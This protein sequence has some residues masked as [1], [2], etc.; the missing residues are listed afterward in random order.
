MLQVTQRTS[1]EAFALVVRRPGE[2]ELI[3]PLSK[4]NTSVGR[5][6]TCDIVIDAP[7]LSRLHA[8]IV[9]QNGTYQVHDQG[10]TT[11]IYVTGQ[12]VTE[13]PLR[14]D[15]P[16]RIPDPYGNVTTLTGRY[17]TA[18]DI[19]PSSPALLS[20]PWRM[21]GLDP[22]RTVL[23]IG[24]DS[25]NDVV[26]DLPLVSRWHARIERQGQILLIRDLNSVNG[27][28]V[29]GW[30]VQ[31]VHPL[32]N[33]DEILI[34][35]ARSTFQDTPL[36]LIQQQGI[37]IDAVDLVRQTSRTSGVILNS[38]S[39]TVLPG[40]FVAI[41]GGSGTGKSALLDAL[42]GILP[43]QSGQVLFNGQDLYRNPAPYSRMI[44]Y[45]PQS[46]ILHH[47]LPVERALDY[48]ARFRLPP[49]TSPGERVRRIS[50]VL[51]DV[52]ME[53]Q[54]HQLVGNLSGGQRKRVSIAVELLTN[55][56]ASVL[57]LD[58]PTSGFDPG[59]DK[60][61]MSL[62]QL[63]CDKGS[64]IVA[65]TNVIENI[66][67]CS[68]VAIMAP[69]GRLV[70]YGPP[71]DAPSFFGVPTFSDIYSFFDQSPEEAENQEQRFHQSAHYRADVLDRRGTFST[72]V[73]AVAP[74]SVSNRNVLTEA[75][76][77]WRILAQRYIE[78]L[79]RDRVN[80][81]LL[82]AQAPIIAVML[83]V[84]S[85]SDS[86]TPAQ[87]NGTQQVLLMLTL[88]AFWFG[89][90]NSAREIVK[91]RSVYL[92]ERMV[93]LRIWPYVLSKFSVLAGISAIQVLVLL[94]LVFLKTPYLPAQG[95][96]FSAPLEIYVTLVLTAL[97]GVA[98]G[99]LISGLVSTVEQAM[100][101]VPVVLIAQ[102]IFSGGPFDLQGPVYVISAAAISRWCLSA[103]GSIVNLNGLAAQLPKPV[104]SWPKELYNSPDVPHLLF[105]WLALALLVIAL[106]V[107]TYV[108]LR[109]RDTRSH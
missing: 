20:A 79:M 99:L 45:V 82:L 6:E 4:A 12:R 41:V 37:R 13:A 66:G 24:R 44:G 27:T 87:V 9:Q 19:I 60:T 46:D 16:I 108:S 90:I 93:N 70:Y 77:Q 83:S 33:G 89:T 64:T 65:V 63:L 107:G 58:E 96:I 10:S 52:K 81:L 21:I 106:L 101:I 1:T 42:S 5:A 80:L 92:H 78:L 75:R 71:A 15:I 25:Q 17:I 23:T 57:L 105:Y 30:R 100:S 91:D 85:Y 7:G 72:P 28:F 48:V 35:P 40:E 29:N 73:P 47:E 31:D 22:H 55:P 109:N 39:L 43:V 61:M 104:E 74:S 84:V 11:G 36:A 68:R 49:D 94:A 14:E 69:R 50:E 38:V 102:V 62:L 67:L 88:A 3:F 98:G 53:P 97:A 34:G 18:D 59:L 54:R 8:L 2:S 26:M 103:L 95:I 86:F 76:R 56:C 32:S 51:A